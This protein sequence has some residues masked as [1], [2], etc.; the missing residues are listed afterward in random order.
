ML[1]APSEIPATTLNTSI[2]VTVCD[3]SADARGIDIL[4][5]RQHSRTMRLVGARCGRMLFCR[6]TGIC[7]PTLIATPSSTPNASPTAPNIG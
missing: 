4:I 3:S 5:A 2:W 1:N 6:S 7:I